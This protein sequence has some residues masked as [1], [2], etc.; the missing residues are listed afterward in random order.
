MVGLRFLNGMVLKKEFQN[1]DRLYIAI[2]IYIYIC[3]HI[4]IYI[5]I[6]I[7]IHKYS[8]STKK[9]KRPLNN[10]HRGPDLFSGERAARSAAADSTAPTGG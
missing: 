10:H 1:L 3:I 5:C 6:Y 8:I 2:H 9:Q 4:H 7:Y